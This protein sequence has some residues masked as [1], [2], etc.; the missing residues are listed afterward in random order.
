MFKGTFKVIWIFATRGWF[1]ARSLFEVCVETIYLRIDKKN[2]RGKTVTVLKGFTRREEELQEL[3]R[4]I[5]SSF[6]TGG[7]VENNCIEI[8]GDFRS[9]IS[10]LLQKLGFSV[11]G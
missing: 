3:A 7:K 5:K 6:G 8:Q 9:P 11:K 2:R 10:T 4:E 1:V